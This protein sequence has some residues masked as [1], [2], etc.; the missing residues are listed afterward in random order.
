MSVDSGPWYS[1]RKGLISGTNWLTLT[2]VVFIGI[3]P[4]SEKPLEL[5]VRRARGGCGRV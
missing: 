1:R 3:L 4:G 5:E 2:V